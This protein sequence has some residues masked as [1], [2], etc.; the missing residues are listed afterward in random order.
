MA[1]RTNQSA[2][3]IPKNSPFDITWLSL[4]SPECLVAVRTRPSGPEVSK[5]QI[6]RGKGWK[7]DEKFRKIRR[8]LK[9]KEYPVQKES[10]VRG[11]DFPFNLK[12]EVAM[13]IVPKELG[14]VEGDMSASLC[15]K[16]FNINCPF[17]WS[18]SKGKTCLQFVP[19]PRPLENPG[20]N[21]V[22]NRLQSNVKTRKKRVKL[23]K[24]SN[25]VIG[26]MFAPGIVM[27]AWVPFL[28][29]LPRVFF[30]GPL[31]LVLLSL[32]FALLL[33][34]SIHELAHALVA[35]LEGVRIKKLKLT[36]IGPA[37]EFEREIPSDQSIKIAS[38]GP[39]S[40]L[41]LAF[42]ASFFVS[43]LFALV[44]ML[45][46]LYLYILNAFP[47]W[48][49]DGSRIFLSLTEVSTTYAYF[50][51]FSLPLSTF[52]LVILLLWVF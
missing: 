23:S 51:A 2:P 30:T 18:L 28:A 38:V 11:P 4:A 34:M 31:K 27:L 35:K 20:E 3:L 29:A 46:S 26:P 14:S 39:A 49:N 44:V 9:D 43:N 41:L 52:P 13:V 50:Y 5:A 17:R 33:S 7:P 25:F 47:S 45:V 16:C 21:P 32:P 48:M 10:T 37:L 6:S 8:A 1:E 22:R 42:V 19:I 24:L 15:E 40:N 36:P 12:K